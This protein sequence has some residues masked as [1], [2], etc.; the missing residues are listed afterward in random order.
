ML[1]EVKSFSYNTHK[2]LD[3]FCDK[4]SRVVDQ[5]YLIYTKDLRM[6]KQTILL[7]IYDTFS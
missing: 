3:A 5:R 2:S 4:F 7:P 1:I 6:D